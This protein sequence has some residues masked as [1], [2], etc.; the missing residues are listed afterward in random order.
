MLSF[1]SFVLVLISLHNN[2]NPKTNV[3]RYLWWNNIKNMFF[4]LCFMC[5]DIL[6]N[7]TYMHPICSVS[8]EIKSEVWT[9]WN[10][11][12]RW[13]WASRSVLRIKP[14]FGR[15]T[16]TPDQ[17]GITL[18]QQKDKCVC[19]CVCSCAYIHLCIC[20]SMYIFMY[21]S[22]YMLEITQVKKELGITYLFY[23]TL[24]S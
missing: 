13:L 20:I 8:I 21:A 4:K 15:G 5:S 18:V 24:V 3:D 7:C 14:W 22:I 1:I 6:P 11:C 2:G 23:H 17:W 12:Y 9:H 16:S 19:L 10:W